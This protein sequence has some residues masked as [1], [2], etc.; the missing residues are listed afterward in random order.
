MIR[1][2][3][4]K[5]LLS[6]LVMFSLL[7]CSK[8]LDKKSDTGLV[9]PQ[10]IEDLQALLDDNT[11]MNDLRTASYGEASADDYYLLDDA[12][13]FSF[14]KTSQDVY[15]W[16]NFIYNYPNDW[17]T[18]YSPIYNA[19]LCLETLGNIQVTPQNKLAWENVKGSAHFYR[20]YY[21]LNIVWTFAKAYDESTADSDLGIVLRLAS[22]FNAPS[23]RSSLKESYNSIMADAEEAI[24]Y[25][26]SV[27]KN[28]FRPSKAAG[29]GLLAR[30]YLSIRN[31]DKA[32][33]YSDLALQEKNVLMDFNGDPDITKSFTNNNG[34]FRTFPYNKEVLFFSS[35]SPNYDTRH[36]AY[37]KID[38]VLFSSY[39]DDDLRK[40][41]YFRSASGWRFKG[42]Y[43]GNG[44]T[45]FTGIAIDEMFLTRAECY[46]RKGQV[47]E[48]MADLNDLLLTRWNNTVAYPTITASDA[49]E[50]LDIILTERR[51]EL[52]MRGLR[53][54]DI[55]RL[56]KEGKNITLERV[57]NGQTYSLQP[58]DE[59]YALPIPKDIIDQTGILQ[60]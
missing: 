18:G 12:Y 33:L 40:K 43:A 9:I 39:S 3:L 50:A 30:I 35:M 49:D 4:F 1:Q 54:M 20:A 36:P 59:R 52:V 29:Y 58:N 8:Y 42:S 45:L 38:T 46:A 17:A 13:N 37:A 28:A 24:N 16:Q 21:H 5:G 27:A 11:I 53:W 34:P 47:A 57:V 48:A 6:S 41:A 25:L 22:D 60:N 32:L 31:Y 14:N 7:G 10:T 44:V 56:N 19:N 2:L 55:K 51:K 15:I 23:T 26:P